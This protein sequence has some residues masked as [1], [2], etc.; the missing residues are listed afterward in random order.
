VNRREK[1]LYPN[2]NF[3]DERLTAL[4]TG[5]ANSAEEEAHKMKV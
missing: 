1:K 2:V 3:V 5:N 4:I